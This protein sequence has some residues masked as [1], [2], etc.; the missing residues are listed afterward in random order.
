MAGIVLSISRLKPIMFRI[1]SQ[2]WY[3]Y[4]KSSLSK[5]FSRQPLKFRAG[6][7]LPYFVEE[8][9]YP[10]FTHA[11][12]HLLHIHDKPISVEVNELITQFPFPVTVVE[13]Q[14]IKKWRKLGVS[15]ELFVLV[16]PDN[17]LAFVFD[18]I[19]SVSIDKYLEQ[20][21]NPDRVPSG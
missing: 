1:I 7:R 14:A 6:D 16:R 5:S 11:S 2:T 8:D 21:F 13:D 10:R 12:F 18:R 9:I 15:K 17:Y 20:H 4:K 19:D 3:S